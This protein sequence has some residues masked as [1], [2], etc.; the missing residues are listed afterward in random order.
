MVPGPTIPSFETAR[1]VF[2]GH[3]LDDLGEYA[4]LWG[5]PEVI[6]FLGGRPFTAEETWHRM[7]RNAGHWAL[8]GYGYWI[9]RERVTE[10][11]V[12]EIGMANL[13]RQLEPALGE[14]PEAGWVLA[15]WCH[16]RGFATEA[17][18]GVLRWGA[19]ALAA[20]RVVCIIRSDHH[21]SLRVAAKCGFR[22]FATS[23]Y[24]AAEVT[25]LE[26]RLGSP[27]SGSPAPSS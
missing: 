17:V 25:Q 20:E 15:P 5:D 19:T 2:R 14:D 18:L 9:V 24:H 4:G 6:K 27:S 23:R 22:S 10:R 12:G 8:M 3:R 26:R 16:G 7:L 21:A 11:F 1:L 13:R